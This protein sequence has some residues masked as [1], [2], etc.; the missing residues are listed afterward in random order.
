[1]PC[2]CIFN[3]FVIICV[4]VHRQSVSSGSCVTRQIGNAFSCLPAMRRSLSSMAMSLGARLVSYA[5][6]PSVL[7]HSYGNIQAHANKI[8][9]LPLLF[10]VYV[11]RTFLLLLQL[12]FKY[13]TVVALGRVKLSNALQILAEIFPKC[14]HVF[15]CCFEILTVRLYCIY[16]NSMDICRHDVSEIFHAISSLQWHL[17]HVLCIHRLYAR[18]QNN[19]SNNKNRNCF[20]KYSSNSA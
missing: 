6:L 17:Q 11:T 18:R 20:R 8:S 14:L 9:T 16:N 10:A 7:S 15:C 13:S 5:H 3:T 2:T 12:P 4:C 1:M 19:N